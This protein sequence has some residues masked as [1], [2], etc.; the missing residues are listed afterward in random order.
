MPGGVLAYFGI[1]LAW[2]VSLPKLHLAN[3]KTYDKVILGVLS[4]ILIVGSI[5]LWTSDA[6]EPPSTYHFPTSS[7]LRGMLFDTAM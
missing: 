2:F 4:L 7:S 1:V 5:L 3:L 6:I